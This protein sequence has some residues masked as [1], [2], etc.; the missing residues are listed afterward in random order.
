ME[1]HLWWGSAEQQAL[2]DQSRPS[3]QF[4]YFDKQLGHPNWEG[5]YRLRFHPG[6]LGFHTH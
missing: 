3:G 6:F 4:A 2:R 5:K 1:V